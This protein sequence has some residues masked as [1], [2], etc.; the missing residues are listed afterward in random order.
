MAAAL[1][2][3]GAIGACAENTQSV[4]S[5]HS[6]TDIR[7]IVLFRKEINPESPVFL[8]KLSHEIGTPL[9]YIGPI[10]GG[11]YLLR[12]SVAPDSVPDV[13]RRLKSQPGVVD[14]QVDVKVRRQ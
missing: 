13:V 9:A 5:V 7:L 1:I 2:G 10:S 6:P 4:A 12:A 8:A 14:A 3:A 11:A